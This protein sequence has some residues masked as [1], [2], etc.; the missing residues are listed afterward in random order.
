M[1][2]KVQYNFLEALVFFL[3]FISFKQGITQT[4]IFR[5]R[6]NIAPNTEAN[7]AT[8]GLSEEGIAW[9]ATC[10][11]CFIS[12][13]PTPGGRHFDVRNGE[14]ENK[15]NEGVGQWITTGAIDIST[16]TKLD[17]TVD[18][19]SNLP[20]PSGGN[21]ESND[22]CGG[23]AGDPDNYPNTGPCGSCWD[24]I[25]VQL[26]LDGTTVY[27]E[28]VGNG[29]NVQTYQFSFSSA[30]FPPGTYSN[31]V[32]RIRTQT[33][34]LGDPEIIWFD[35]VHLVAYQAPTITLTPVG[36]YCVDDNNPK[37][38][39]A[40][41][42]G[43]V[44]SGP[45]IIGSTFTP[46]IAGAGTHILTYTYQSAATGNCP[47]TET[48]Q[49]V[50]NPAPTAT[51][52]VSPTNICEGDDFQLN[53]SGGTSYQWSG[54]NGF[55]SN[56]Q[57]PTITNSG[58]TNAGT[59]TVTVTDGNNCTA[60]A[61][62]DVTI[63]ALPTA[64]ANANPNPICE[65]QTLNLTS[66][67]GTSYSW[68]G[69]V[70]FTSGD[71]NPVINNISTTQA[72]TYSVTV[73]SNA[74]CNATT[75]ISVTVNTNPTVSINPIPDLCTSDPIYTPAGNPTG[76]TWTFNGIPISDIDPSA[77]TPGSYILVYNYTDGNGCS[78][79]ASITVNIVDCGC[80]NPPDVDAGAD[81]SIC[82]GN[83]YTLSGTATNTSVY[84]WSTGGDGTFNN[85][86]IL[87]P[88]YTPGPG[89]IASGIVIITI[90]TPDPDGL[91]PC[92]GDTDAMTL[93]IN[94][95]PVLNFPG[96]VNI[97]EN[98]CQTI[99]MSVTGGS[100]SYTANLVITS[101]INYSIPAITIN[102]T[103]NFTICYQ[104]VLPSFNSATNTLQVPP[105]LVPT[106]TNVTFALTQLVDNNTSCQGVL[107]GSSNT[108]ITVFTNPS[109]TA[110]PIGP[111][112]SDGPPV[113]LSGNPTGGTWSGT[114]VINGTFNPTVSGPGFFQLT[115]TYTDSN[116]CTGT[117]TTTVQVENCN[118]NLGIVVNAGPDMSSCISDPILLQG[119]VINSTNYYWTTSGDGI[120]SNINDLNATYTPGIGDAANGSV[121]LIL[122]VP[123][124]DD[125]GPCTD[126]PD[127][128]TITFI[129]PNI[130]INTVQPLCE[131]GNIVTLSGFPT[132]GTFTGTGINGD[133]FDPSIAGPGDHLITYTA[134]ENGCT[135]QAQ[136]IIHVEAAPLITITPVSPLCDT[137]PPVVLSATPSG[138]VFSGAGVNGDIFDP[139]TAGIGTK[140]INY[141]YQ[142][143]FGCTWTET[144]N[145][146]VNN[147]ACANPATAD[148]GGD[149]TSCDGN[150]VTI[151][152]N[153]N[154]SVA[155][156]TSGN[157]FFLPND[158]D[159]TTYYPS[160]EDFTNGSVVLTM[161]TIDPDGA[162]P[163][164]PATSSMTL[165][166]NIIN[167][168]ISLITQVC[169]S[170]DNIQL[171]ALPAGGTWTGNGVIMNEFVPSVAG[172]G[173]HTL[174]YIVTSNG[175][176]ATKTV[177]ITVSPA[178]TVT[179]TP[180]SDLCLNAPAIV[181][182]G[183]SPTGGQ[184]YINGD[185]N[186]PVTTFSPTM[187]GTYTI[188]YVAG[189]LN[190]KGNNTATITV[191]DC[192]C[193]DPVSVNVGSNQTIC[194][195]QTAQVLATLNN[196]I[197]G[198]WTTSGDGTFSVPTGYQSEYIPGTN[199]ILSG[200][201]TLTYTTN[202][203]DDAGP[204][205]PASAS[206][207]VTIIQ[208]PDIVISPIQELCLDDLPV[209]LLA[210]PT[211]GLWTG[212]GISG[213]QFD[214]AKAG[215]G[216]HTLTYTVGTQNCTA[217]KAITITVK[218]C[219]CPLTIGVDA[220]KD[221]IVCQP[222]ILR[223]NGSLTGISTGSWTSSG[224]GSF[225][226]ANLITPEY[227]PSPEDINN[228]SVTLTFTSEDPDGAGPCLSVSDDVVVMI[229][230]APDVLLLVTQPNCI[231]NTGSIKIN[232]ISGQNLQYSIDNG[233]TFTTD[234]TI[235]NIP[236]GQY[237][238]I[239]KNPAVLCQ[240]TLDFSIFP[241]TEP[242]GVWSSI[243]AAC[244]SQP[245][246]SFTLESTDEL[247]LPF[248]AVV[249]GVSYPIINSLPYVFDGLQTGAYQ[250][251]I[252]DK[253]GC[254]MSKKF[255]FDPGS[256]INVTL[257]PVIVVDKGASALIDLKISGS[258]NTI[259]WTP[260][261]YL[262]CSDCSN[263]IV[264]PLENT[265]YTVI[266][267]DENGCQDEATVLVRIRKHVNVF[268]PNAI[269]PNHDGINDEFTV[270][271]DDEVSLV[272]SMKI[273]NRWGGVVFSKEN[274][275]PNDPR[276]GWNGRFKEQE[277]NPAVFVY[278]IELEMKDGK[279]KLY[280][281][282]FSLIR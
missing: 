88:T 274:F 220:G 281:G 12:N 259:T 45:G 152:G 44:W 40:S 117:A 83:T 114:G 92:I 238:L 139:G 39:T 212:K 21:M 165:T 282:E 64:T 200:V 94:Q 95:T 84:S 146:T 225:N 202:D 51:A 79:S 124:P 177:D 170:S 93:T 269:S 6:F 198:A 98:T 54:P 17:F 59:Y 57:N 167:I 263:P 60:T 82:S 229:E 58:S 116:G 279:T 29:N 181:L 257:D 61:T 241:F 166:F 273:F 70:G 103:A 134:S 244:S 119:N 66:S 75:S 30:C 169:E 16:A 173:I 23:C 218:D 211:G 224:T 256:S 178:P 10:P 69:P 141:T 222:G 243:S 192:S 67:G 250:V 205:S 237:Q 31:A 73:T 27:N 255:V 52:G 217:T 176:T 161:T 227:A 65:G 264:S 25:N 162:G 253:N 107:S 142:D 85:P 226:D 144:I 106:G 4:T 194:S 11:L 155:W 80:I 268:I 193:V 109:V 171:F 187:I 143:L 208:L 71:Q 271:T 48:M 128:L 190:C 115:Y 184:Y 183:G 278:V 129:S 216:N 154:Y 56:L 272:R 28:T 140:T 7:G 201:V 213:D 223:L 14:F 234:Q 118:C 249:N 276:L 33:W 36:P 38:L 47:V 76:G 265:E 130:S 254:T 122:I 189:P 43:G 123:D 111:L 280:K 262:S 113:N 37:A 221:T 46:S 182:S 131:G 246:N 231:K 112:C 235:E 137:D 74:G 91:G 158:Q 180:F 242:Q 62:V 252:T 87:N 96:G 53:S 26:I 50:V 3:L 19:H 120:F 156:S 239:V 9:T 168:Q 247:T 100:G 105:T 157:G 97:C 270:Y 110:N 153:S 136:I 240:A 35:D 261:L 232:V 267:K 15:A 108:S 81:A 172:Q 147:C 245:L 89:D 275:A 260:A 174:T 219:G 186:N 72:G 199:D 191:K 68:T 104:G 102:G 18:Y 24:F 133:T 197:G 121:T 86:N 160:S 135:G 266:V 150:G 78:N 277:L 138:G 151:N 126:I 49:V 99:T 20:W 34:S 148:A 251:E 42:S 2:K 77:Y 230:K 22:E 204:C 233:V 236:P 214:P 159:T 127:Q 41:P 125:D 132:G 210:S 209:T 8:S 175:C 55:T 32:I 196:N 215:P 63:N 145:I 149:M 5:E 163:C 258:Y 228:G 1:K 90:T 195:N 188:T 164:L 207:Q 13:P 203:P 101:P 206:L 248:Q 185:F 179:L